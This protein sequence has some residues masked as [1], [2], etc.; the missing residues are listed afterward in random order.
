M[1]MPGLLDKPRDQYTW[2]R[3]GV[4]Y[5]WDYL[6]AQLTAG[7]SGPPIHL[8]VVRHAESAANASGMITG[9]SDAELTLRGY[10]QALGLGFRLRYKYDVAWV[11]CLARTYKTIQ[12]AESLRFQKISRRP[13]CADSRLNERCLG[14]LEGTPRRRIDAYAAGDLL[15]APNGGESYL[16]LAQRLLSFLL[17]LRRDTQCETRAIVATHVGPMRLLVGIINDLDD[18][19]SVLGQ[20]FSNA[21]T[22][23]CVFRDLRWP[24]FIRK[25]VLH[26]RCE[27]DMGIAFKAADYSEV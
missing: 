19:R 10:V 26:G 27:Q 15:Y 20:R 5:Q 21:Q 18:P 9:Q 23:S 25:E 8:H 6:L 7:L 13:I 2:H 16:D 3:R 1:I 12:V 4:I 14:D 24:A 11:S 17:D 22:Y